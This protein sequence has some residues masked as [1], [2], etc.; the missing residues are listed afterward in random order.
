MTR[1][2]A[3][4]GI[5]VGIM[6]VCAYSGY[7]YRDVV[8]AR[9][10]AQRTIKTMQD[11]ADLQNDAREAANQYAIKR[12]QLQAEVRIVR[13]QADPVIVTLDRCPLPSGAA[14]ILRAAADAADGMRKPNPAGSGPNGTSPAPKFAPAK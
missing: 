11:L 1:F 7:H 6:A 3:E 9:D 12:D 8:Y 14:D 13:V 10:D 5:V 2:L 4:L